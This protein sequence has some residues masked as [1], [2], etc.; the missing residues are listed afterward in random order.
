VIDATSFYGAL[1]GRIR[2]L[3]ERRGLTLE[4]MISRGFAA[5]HWQQIEKGRPMT[6]TTLLRIALVFE[7]SLD[8]LVWRLPRPIL[9]SNE[10][11]R[12]IGR[13]K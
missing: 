4:D 10:P 3:R 7:I 1:G 11:Q 12:L 6:C 8:S 2:R 5:R 13:A 9:V